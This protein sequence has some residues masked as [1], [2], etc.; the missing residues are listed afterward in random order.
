MFFSGCCKIKDGSRYVQLRR[1]AREREGRVWA[2]RI[3]PTSPRFDV[4]GSAP[5]FPRFDIP[6][7]ASHFFLEER[8]DNSFCLLWLLSFS[9]LVVSLTAEEPALEA[10]L[11]IVLT[12]DGPSGHAS[13]FF[14]SAGSLRTDAVCFSKFEALASATPSLGGLVVVVMVVV[15]TGPVTS[16]PARLR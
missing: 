12:P 9:K 2:F 16:I 10:S 15:T 5:T 13:F 7:S 8:G 6:G 14:L 11:L 1:V 4:P 3:P